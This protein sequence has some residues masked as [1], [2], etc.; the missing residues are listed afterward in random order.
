LY[1]VKNSAYGSGSTKQLVIVIIVTHS[2]TDRRHFFTNRNVEDWNKIPSC[3]KRAKTVKVSKM[4][5]L[6]SELTWWKAR[7]MELAV[8]RF[9]C[10][11]HTFSQTLAKRPYLGHC[12]ST[13]TSK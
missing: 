2:K 7:D 9:E 13:S 11:D 10:V 4:A 12:E 5:M 8:T 1:S 3:L 6:I